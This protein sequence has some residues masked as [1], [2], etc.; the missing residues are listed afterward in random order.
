MKYLKGLPVNNRVRASLARLS[1]EI[2]GS[3]LMPPNAVKE[4]H[5]RRSEANPL[6]TSASSPALG[7]NING[8][9]VIRVPA[10]IRNA[11]GRYY[12]YFAH[13]KGTYIRLAYADK[14]AGPWKIYEPGT[15][16]L[17]QAAGFRKHIASPDVHVDEENREIRMYFHGP[18]NDKKGQY[19]GVAISKDGLAFK[20][21]DQ[22]LGKCYFRV[23]RWN[24]YYYAIAKNGKSGWG[25]LYRSEDGLTPFESGGNFV[26]MM[27]HCAVSVCDRHLLIFYSRVGDAPERIV[28]A[29]I[30]LKD[31]WKE[32][33]ISTPVDVITPE[34]KYEGI[35]YT[36]K[37]SCHGNATEVRQIRDP[38]V[39]EENGHTYLFYS[40]AG[41][42]GIAMAEITIRLKQ[43][44][45]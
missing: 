3:A 30:S 38:C 24:G 43:N 37:P 11:L 28:L 31:D 20:V 1:A 40:V 15:L 10:W 2:T 44:T 42:M 5:A 36:N 33:R 6:I 9:S 25:E 8:P 14:L 32:W 27:R 16:Q 19:T 39:F 12:M 29:T 35:V 13:H 17:N 21:F 41:E 23:F 18:V 26:R 7:E 22:I 34:T 4:I 45:E